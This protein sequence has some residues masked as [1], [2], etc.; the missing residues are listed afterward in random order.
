[1]I[2]LLKY[3]QWFCQF[4]FGYKFSGLYVNKKSF[5]LHKYKHKIYIDRCVQK[6][7]KGTISNTISNKHTK[8]WVVTCIKNTIKNKHR[9]TWKKILSRTFDSSTEIARK[10]HFICFTFNPA[11]KSLTFFVS[12]YYFNLDKMQLVCKIEN[13]ASNHNKILHL[14]LILNF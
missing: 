7:T 4:H 14:L 8:T 5:L 10:S 3:V 1:M 12:I 2:K 6:S 11:R 9:K 13:T